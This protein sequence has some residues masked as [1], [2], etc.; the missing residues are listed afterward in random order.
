MPRLQPLSTPPINTTQTAATVGVQSTPPNA[1]AFPTVAAEST[2]VSTDQVSVAAQ[3]KA[4]ASLALEE[5][6]FTLHTVK[7]GESLTSIAQ[8]YLGDPREFMQ[9]YEANKDAM[10]NPNNLDIGM[11]LKIPNPP[12][13]EPQAAAPQAPS[14]S[15][16]P[17]SPRPQARPNAAPAA[18]QAAAEPPAPP[19][20]VEHVVKRGETLS[21]IALNTLDD[22]ERYMEIY[23]ANKD[24]MR[25]PNA[26]QV[27]MTL[28]IPNG[29]AE[30]QLTEAQEAEAA[31]A[32]SAVDASGLTPGATELL[33]AMKRYQNH[34]RELGNSQR[35]KTTP[36]QMREIA[37]ELDQA[38]RTFDVDPKMMLALFAHES[39][40][41][42][43]RARSHT[44]AGGLGQLTGIAIRQV[45][46]M[47]GIAKGFRG[48]DPFN[49]HKSKFV[50]S[51]RSIEQ[52]YDIKANVWTS[53]AYMSYELEG[54]A[55]MGRGVENALKRYGDPNVRTYANKVNDEYRTLFGQDLF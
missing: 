22:S 6:S 30:V 21:T 14:A 8:K 52:R 18:P 44:G 4:N 53:T 26:L 46:H 20:F 19:A 11:T 47:S 36:A 43:P 31:A 49:D 37:I 13:A 7:R 35:T 12:A 3:G 24:Q 32:A 10:M 42:N 51:T 27:G 29:H 15:P 5:P 28:K 40:G 34:H 45:H 16:P 23:E 50:Q 41:I 48:Q 55:H 38:G 39:G 9:I 1:V 17:S 33:E 2:R 25:S 54:R